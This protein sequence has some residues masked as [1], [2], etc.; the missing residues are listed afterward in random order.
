M[1]TT[2]LIDIDD[3]SIEKQGYTYKEILNKTLDKI[4]DLYSD[5][6]L[7]FD[8]GY[9]PETITDSSIN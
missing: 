1:R 8:F 4:A 7:S 9:N 3:N 6:K 5:L 2:I